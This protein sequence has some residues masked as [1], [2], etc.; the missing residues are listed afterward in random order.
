MKHVIKATAFCAAALIAMN[1]CLGA[2]VS[3]AADVPVPVIVRD[4]EDAPTWELDK[5]TLTIHAS[6]KD[7]AYHYLTSR[8]WH[9]RI[10]EIRR[11]VLEDGLTCVADHAFEDCTNLTLVE[12]PDSLETIGDSAFEGCTSLT[13]I[14]L[15]DNLTEIE[16]EAFRNCTSLKAVSFPESLT[17][18]G[19]GAF[20]YC[21]SLENI[22]FSGG[23][24]SVGSGIFDETPWLEEQLEKHDFVIVDGILIDASLKEGDIVIPD[25]VKIIG[26]DAFQ[27][28]VDL[29]SVKL[30]DSLTEIGSWAFAFCEG[31]TYIKIPDSV[32]W[33]GNNAF[34]YC[35]G[36]TS[37][38]IPDSVTSV[39]DDVFQYCSGLTEIEFPPYV[40]SCEFNGCT[41]LKV[42]TFRNPICSIEPK[43]L[44]MENKPL[45]EGYTGSTAELFAKANGCQFRSIGDTYIGLLGKHAVTFRIDE[46]STVKPG[47][48]YTKY[49]IGG[50]YLFSLGVDIAEAEAEVVNAD[51]LPIDAKCTTVITSPYTAKYSFLGSNYDVNS[52]VNV[53][54]SC[55]VKDDAENGEYTIKVAFTRLV[56]ADGHDL[57]PYIR[58]EERYITGKFTVQGEIVEPTQ[59][60]EATTE[61][62]TDPTEPTA[63]VDPEVAFKPVLDMFNKNVSENWGQ[64]DGTTADGILNSKDLATISSEWKEN[65]AD[66]PGSKN[67]SEVGYEYRN[68]V[69]AVGVKGGEYICDAYT[70]CDGEII[71]LCSTGG[72]HLFYFNDD[73]DAMLLDSTIPDNLS[74]PMTVVYCTL[75]NGRVK[76]VSAAKAEKQGAQWVYYTTNEVILEADG[77]YSYGEWEKIEDADHNM[78]ANVHYLEP[79]TFSEIQ[80][81][82]PTEPTEATEPTEV[83]ETTEPTDSTEP[84]EPTAPTEPIDTN[85]PEALYKDILDFFRKNIGEGWANY[86]APTDST[87]KY[88]LKDNFAAASAWETNVKDETLHDTGY[89]FYDVNGDDVP[90]LFIASLDEDFPG[91]I[92]MY[93]YYD[94]EIRHLVSSADKTGYHIGKDEIVYAYV[95]GPGIICTQFGRLQDGVLV[96]YEAYQHGGESPLHAD[97]AEERS[98][99]Y[100][101]DWNNAEK[102]TMET[103]E[104]GVASHEKLQ[105]SYTLFDGSGKQELPELSE[106]SLGDL[107]VD[108]TVNASDAAQVLIAAAAIGAGQDPGLTESQMSVADVN[109]DK[110]INASD[111]A[112]ILI[113]A[114]AIGAGQDVK[115]TDFVK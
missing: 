49:Y 100:V 25:N 1:S 114:A 61:N 29:T 66:Q 43:T 41:S 47:E 15:P 74:D 5:G 92:E 79:K 103:L 39:G 97:H 75:E 33:I 32:T 69:L 108:N 57:L 22:T 71:H 96:P 107:N 95:D 112:I 55:D 99:G 94:G 70:V 51:E 80:W 89:L 52:A 42:V 46:N 20:Q 110:T 105:L 21:S 19:S 24:T 98:F 73:A 60:T 62:S 35:E 27:S 104:A 3:V 45:I 56:D 115:L 48:H 6:N 2:M 34:G 111:A 86:T 38:T 102:L 68:G 54:V 28:C 88:P 11:V 113:Y 106:T 30:P 78:W 12:L 87:V 65:G 17:D 63:P 59:P 82:T 93:T 31:L 44:S 90:E 8:P 85:D 13:R 23:L 10:D 84:T 53:N 50:E 58:E 67:A 77:S 76:P 72:S 26:T 37:L 4:S 7:T 83:T 40:N 14:D 91:F 64:F 36:L 101:F 81:E 9:E 18:I 16:W 109:G